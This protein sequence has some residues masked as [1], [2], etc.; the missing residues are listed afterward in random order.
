M[1]VI[2]YQLNVLFAK[3]HVFIISKFWRGKEESQT[4]FFILKV[5]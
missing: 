3:K 1:D 5:L 2:S 4:N